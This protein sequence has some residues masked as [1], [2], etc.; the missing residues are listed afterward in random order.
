VLVPTP[1]IQTGQKGAFVFVVREDDTV[2]MRPVSTG[3]T[4]EGSTVVAGGLKVGDIVVTDGQL[5]LVPGS[6]VITLVANDPLTGRDSDP[7]SRTI[8]VVRA[9]ASPTPTGGI[10]LTAPTDGAALTGPVEIRGSAAPGASLTVSATLVAAAE[11][12]FSIV[13]PRG[14]EVPL[15]DTPPT[16]PE[17]QTIEVGGDGRIDVTLALLPGSWEISVAGREGEATTR[18]ITVAAADGLLGALSVTGGISYL[19]VEED[20]VPKQ[21]ISG[22][23]ANPDTVV[24]LVAK[25]GLRIRVGNAGAVTLMINGVDLGTMGGSGA[26][27]EWRIIRL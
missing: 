7:V 19:E 3:P 14:V 5:R 24:D 21:G 15:P 13:D 26:V 4:Y 2:E 16:A 11:P 17:P 1:A 6:N 20:G 9:E 12:T 25:Q 23:N 18:S 27:V 8:V 10:T 22:R